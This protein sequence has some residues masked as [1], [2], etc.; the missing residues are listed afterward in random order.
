MINNADD[1]INLLESNDEFR[2]AVR[3]WVLTEELLGLPGVVRDLQGQV[4]DVE[5]RRSNVERQMLEMQGQIAEM[6]GQMVEMQRQMV[7]MNARLIRVESDVAVLKID[8][9]VLK[10]DVAVLKIDVKTIKDDIGA[11]KGWQLQ[12]RLHRSGLQ[13]IGD[14]FGI[15]DPKVIR[16]VGDGFRLPDFNRDVRR[17]NEEGVLSDRE[18][19]RLINTDMIMSGRRES[20]GADVYVVA[21]AS[22]A[23]TSADIEKVLYSA[24]LFKKVYPE[25]DVRTALWY[26]NVDD[27]RRNAAET[28]GVELVRTQVKHG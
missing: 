23:L 11:L 20:D 14:R 27:I 5:K 28:E 22:F 8:V 17:A 24:D 25:R 12:E 26:V 10:D 4:A 21:E 6:Q 1:I 7:E 16:A 2:S 15:P 19:Q 13:Q 3:R 9:A 18:Y